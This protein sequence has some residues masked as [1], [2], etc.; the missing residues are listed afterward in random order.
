MPF[1]PFDVAAMRRGIE[2]ARRGEG[3]V[4]PNPLVGAVVTAGERIIAEGWHPRFGGPHAEVVALDAAGAGARGATLYVTLEP[5]CHHGKTPPCTEAVIAAGIGRVVIAVRDP[6]PTVNGGGIAALRAAGLAVE[7]GLLEA[8]ALRLT[9]PFRTLVMAGRPWVIAKWAMSRDRR[10]AAPPGAG[11]WI[12]SPESRALVHELRGRM[13]AILVGIGTALADDPL[14]TARPPGPRVPLRIVLDSRAR[15]PLDSAL[16]Q[17]VGDAPLLVAV[18]PDAPAARI[19]AL[20]SAGCEV[21]QSTAPSP[22]DRLHA[23]LRFLGDRRLTNLLVEGGP[24]VLQEFFAAGLIDEIWQFT[25]PC[26]YASHPAAALLPVFDEP[27]P[28]DVESVSHPGGDTLVKG[29]VRRGV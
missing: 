26:D 20:R 19:A 14:L 28:F 5:C 18:G 24:H 6:F 4:E 21:W 11:R 12:S 27:P 3:F 22:A 17:S 7:T 15:L 13:D 29:V 8:E 25:A 23:L 10:A 16:A 1:S 2:L 9:A